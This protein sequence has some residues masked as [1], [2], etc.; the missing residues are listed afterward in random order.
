MKIKLYDCEVEIDD[1]IS[2]EVDIYNKYV[3]LSNDAV[4]EFVRFYDAASG[5]GEVISQGKNI[6]YNQYREIARYTIALCANNG[7][8]GLTEDD[9]LKCH[10]KFMIIDAMDAISNKSDSIKL[11]QRR[12]E[13]YRERRKQH[14]GKKIDFVKK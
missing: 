12:E 6:A 2:T 5:I 3:E 7:V 10:G 11:Q 9:I 4:K 1:N 14:R 13:S 8:F